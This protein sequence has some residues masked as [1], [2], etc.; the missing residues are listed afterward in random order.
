M[1]QDQLSLLSAD[2]ITELSE[3]DKLAVEYRQGVYSGDQLRKSRP[4][5]YALICEL[6]AD[7]SMSQRQI[8]NVTGHSRNLISAISRQSAD[9]EPL[10]EKIAGRAR[11]LAQICLE[12]AEEIVTEGGKVT[13]RD[14]AILA[15]VAI[16]KSQLLSGEATQRIESIDSTSGADDFEEQFKALRQADVQELPDMGLAAEE[17]HTKGTGPDDLGAAGCM[18][19]GGSLPVKPDDQEGAK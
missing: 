10:K 17:P 14:L 16:D 4:D 9:I 6:L 15:G 11:N 1:N 12:R 7:G 19:G 18:V 2:Q 5:M 13:L 3:S 8:S